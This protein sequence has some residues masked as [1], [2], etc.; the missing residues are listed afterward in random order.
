M[1]PF[2]QIRLTLVLIAVHA[3]I[4]IETLIAASQ[5]V[6]ATRFVGRRIHIGRCGIRNGWSPVSDVM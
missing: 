1:L 4:L 6:D 3:K 2:S 5:V